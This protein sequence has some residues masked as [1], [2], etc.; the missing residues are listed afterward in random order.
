[1]RLIQ[2]LHAYK[3]VLFCGSPSSILREPIDL[4]KSTNIGQLFVLCCNSSKKALQ[5]LPNQCV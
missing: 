4:V 3:K 1:M 5:A 2:C